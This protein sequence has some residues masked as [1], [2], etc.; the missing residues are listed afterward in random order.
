LISKRDVALIVGEMR[1]ILEKLKKNKEY[2][3]PSFFE[4]YTAL[5]LKYFLKQK[6]DFAVLETGL[7]GRLDATNVVTPLVSVI[8]HIGYDHMD[9]LGN[10]LSEIAH[11][12]AGIIKRNVPVV[13]APQEKNVLTVIKKKCKKMRAPLLVLGKNFHAR[14]IRIENNRTWFDFSK[15]NF[16]LKDTVINIKGRVQVENAACALAAASFLIKNA[17]FLREG[18]KDAFLEGRFEA[19]SKNPLTIVDVA[20]NLS[21]FK[22]VNDNLKTYFPGR[23]VIL[24]FGAS[25]DKDVKKMLKVINYDTIILTTFRNPRAFTSGEIRDIC[26]LK[27][28]PITSGIKEAYNL[29]KRLYN[30]GSLILISGSFFLVAEAKKAVPMVP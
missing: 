14:N 8:T 15:D 16:Q 30:N 10:T 26:G 1:P 29:A 2:E 25:K 6:C 27:N 18:S 17:V 9:K 24:I 12:K 22:A 7:G 3:A 19:V 4:V 11:E 21:S 28:A 20:H 5:A 13:S 23:K